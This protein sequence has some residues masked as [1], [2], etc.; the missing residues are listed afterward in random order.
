MNRWALVVILTVVCGATVTAQKGRRV[1]VKTVVGKAEA[2]SPDSTKIKQLRNGM[3]VMYGWNI[4]TELEASVELVFDNGALFRVGEAS[5]ITL[6]DNLG[7]K[8]MS[9]DKKAK[10]KDTL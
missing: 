1:T 6:S 2:I 7:K 8:D 4:R 9:I 10:R 5:N 3:R